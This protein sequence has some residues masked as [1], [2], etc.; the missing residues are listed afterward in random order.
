MK[1]YYEVVTSHQ[2]K[3]S[4]RCGMCLGQGDWGMPLEP[5]GLVGLKD[6]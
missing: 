2:R 1:M 3:E 5:G 6:A 4:T